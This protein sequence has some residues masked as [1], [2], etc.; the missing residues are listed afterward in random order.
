[1]FQKEI[2]FDLIKYGLSDGTAAPYKMSCPGRRDGLIS[3]IRT[4]APIECRRCDLPQ[5]GKLIG[6]LLG[7]LSAA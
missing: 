3:S 2:F 1:M 5:C 7:G 6:E 4:I